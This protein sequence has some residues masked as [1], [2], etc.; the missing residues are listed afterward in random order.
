MQHLGIA[1]LRDCT[2]LPNKTQCLDWRCPKI[3]AAAGIA[4]I[5]S[6]AVRQGLCTNGS[7]WPPR[8]SPG[9]G[10]E[11]GTTV[12]G[13]TAAAA[14]SVENDR[15][16]CLNPG[17]S[18]QQ[19]RTSSRYSRRSRC[20][21]HTRMAPPCQRTL[22]NLLP[23]VTVV[24]TQWRTVRRSHYAGCVACKLCTPSAEAIRC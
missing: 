20:H 17:V 1:R 2:P 24:L 15:C 10:N 14:I 21:P 19:P 3:V 23:S 18:K 9:E 11:T 6:D 8:L 13:S 12:L 22:Q 16:T 4:S 5:R 7:C